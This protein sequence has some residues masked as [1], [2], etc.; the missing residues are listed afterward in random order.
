MI[1]ILQIAAGIVLGFLIL[2]AYPGSLG[3]CADC[4]A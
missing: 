3:S 1:L 2:R 4:G